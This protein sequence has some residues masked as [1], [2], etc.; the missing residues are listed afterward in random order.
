MDRLAVD[1]NAF[2]AFR[3]GNENVRSFGSRR[4]VLK[5]KPD[6]LLRTSILREL[7]DWF[8]CDGEYQGCRPSCCNET[9]AEFFDRL[10]EVAVICRWHRA[11]DVLVYTPKE[12]EEMR[13]SNSFIRDE[14]LQKGQVLY[15]RAA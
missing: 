13:H 14:V 12:F 5:Q 4:R 9:S 3:A 15:D 8:C 7:T 2:I 6:C 10:K 1:S 11:V